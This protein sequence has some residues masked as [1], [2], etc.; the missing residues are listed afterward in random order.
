MYTLEI[1]QD[2]IRHM[3]ASYFGEE[4]ITIQSVPADKPG[5]LAVPVFA[6]AKKARRNLTEMAEAIRSQLDLGLTLF[7]QVEVAGGYLNFHFDRLAFQ[8]SVID[9][10]RSD[11]AR[12][13]HDE[14]TQPERVVIDYSSPNVAKP[15]H[16]GHIRSTGIGD[17]LARIY[18]FL[19]HQ[20]IRQNH[21][22]DWGTQFGQLIQYMI[23]AG[24]AP[25]G[26]M[27]ME[28]I[29]EIYR[30][31][32]ERFDGEEEFKQRA[33]E[34]VA[35]LQSGDAE[36]LRYWKYLIDES[37]LSFN[38]IYRQLGVLLTDDDVRGESSY[39]D[40]LA[41]TVAR[42]EEAGLVEESDGAKVVFLNNYTDP[43]TSKSYPWEAPVIVQKRDGAFNY[44]T[45]DL[46]AL[47]YR[48]ETLM[49][50]RILYVIDVRQGDH[51]AKFFAVAQQAGWLSHTVPQ[52]V[53]FG[54]IM[55]ADG[56]P[57]KTREGGTVKLADVLSES[58]VRAKALIQEKLAERGEELAEGEVVK[59]ARIIGIGAVKYGDLAQDRNRNYEFNWKR[60]LALEGNTA[61]Y[62][63]YVVV[64]TRSLF[65]KAAEQSI[66]TKRT[67][68]TVPLEAL[69]E[70]QLLKRLAEWPA[71][72][73]QA[74]GENQPFIITGYLFTLAQAYS[75]FYEAVPILKTEDIALRA[76]RLELA[77]FTANVLTTGL[78][79]L[80]IQVP[81][82]M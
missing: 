38:A 41:T 7:S 62:L 60:M 80:G 35:Q 27:T 26:E 50:D 25:E 30:A 39:N 54:T 37:M 1:A 34:R 33:R 82:R 79:L 68:A 19:G 77:Q 72:V 8:R 28:R 58:E 20:V 67:D 59:L 40:D 49:A 57:F 74:A 42:L 56:K 47:Y 52:F 66:D 24:I 71:V 17:A 76:T 14:P 29:E 13:G 53:G 63:Q 64:R 6:L 75:S 43:T 5:D 18:T 10:Y 55:G 36:S 65:R 78:D 9:D 2:Q 4:K 16:V 45:T 12:Y 44:D 73:K 21:L 46:A 3:L 15:M 69:T 70:W 23:E 61:P 48:I 11:P 51:C 32:K 81:D 31:S 22:G